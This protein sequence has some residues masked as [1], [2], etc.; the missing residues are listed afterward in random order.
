MANSVACAMIFQSNTAATTYSNAI[1]NTAKIGEQCKAWIVMGL[2]YVADLADR[3]ACMRDTERQA[4]N[5]ACTQKANHSSPTKEETS[6][7]DT[8]HVSKTSD[9]SQDHASACKNIQAFSLSHRHSFVYVSLPDNG[10]PAACFHAN[11]STV[12]PPT[13]YPI[14]FHPPNPDIGTH[15][16]W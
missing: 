3:A 12:R 1:S 4:S 2:T 14:P 7:T 13:S 11:A 8:Q 16:S 9:K 15:R 10:M 6:C 5:S